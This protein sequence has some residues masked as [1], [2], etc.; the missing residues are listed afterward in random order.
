[1][2]QQTD[3]PL[4]CVS[5]AS[6]VI[7]TDAD[8]LLMEDTL[9]SYSVWHHRTQAGEQSLQQDQPGVALVHYLAAMEQ[10]HYWLG[11]QTEQTPLTQR[12]EALDIWLRSCLNLVRFWYIQSTPSE[13]LRYLRQ[14]LGYRSLGAFVDRPSETAILPSLQTLQQSLTHFIKEHAEMIQGDELHQELHRLNQILQQEAE[15]DKRRA[16]AISP[17]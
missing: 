13:Q 14:A 4:K 5:N 9:M 3:G 12:T 6:L 7:L 15:G 1:M 10:A 8:E 16:K 17:E 11:Q 2:R